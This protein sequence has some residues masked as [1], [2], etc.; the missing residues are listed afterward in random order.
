M[1]ALIKVYFMLEESGCGGGGCGSSDVTVDDDGD[2][3]VSLKS[4]VPA[5]FILLLPLSARF[6]PVMDK[7]DSSSRIC[8][9]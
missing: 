4:P 7:S 8:L 3:S 2:V 1:Y 9:L 5:P 6:V